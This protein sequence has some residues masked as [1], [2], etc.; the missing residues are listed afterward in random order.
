MIGLD[1]CVPDVKIPRPVRGPGDPQ[2]FRTRVSLHGAGL[3]ETHVPVEGRR[4]VVRGLLA[5]GLRRRQFHVLAQRF[6]EVRVGAVLD[7]RLGALGFALKKCL[8]K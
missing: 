3:Q 7:D 1:D 8:E 2:A 5:V 6:L 4:Q